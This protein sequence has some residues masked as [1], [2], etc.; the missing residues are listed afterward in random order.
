MA[1][2]PL[3]IMFETMGPCFQTGRQKQ[4]SQRALKYS[5]DDYMCD[6]VLK[7]HVPGKTSASSPADSPS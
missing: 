5:L 1:D 4:A 7:L 3:K 6:I 2:L